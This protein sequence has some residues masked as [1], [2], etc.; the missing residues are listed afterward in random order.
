MKITKVYFEAFPNYG[1]YKHLIGLDAKSE[2]KKN[3]N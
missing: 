1:Y 2:K 3:E